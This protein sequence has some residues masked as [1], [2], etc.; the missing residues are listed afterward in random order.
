MVTLPVAATWARATVGVLASCWVLW[1][2]AA[3]LHGPAL[4]NAEVCQHG[5]DFLVAALA[6]VEGSAHREECVLLGSRVGKHAVASCALQP[7][8]WL[9][10][11]QCITNHQTF[12]VRDRRLSRGLECGLT[13][14]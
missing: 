10:A 5:G 11:T 9:D 2:A 1:M 7:G 6:L 13:S 3:V 8:A 4:G 14:P 12:C